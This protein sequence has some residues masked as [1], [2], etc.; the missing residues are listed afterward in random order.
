MGHFQTLSRKF[1]NVLFGH[2]KGD[3]SKNFEK[4]TFKKIVFFFKNGR[5]LNKKSGPT[6]KS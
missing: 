5:F 2:E 1:K 6:L 3:I 4:K